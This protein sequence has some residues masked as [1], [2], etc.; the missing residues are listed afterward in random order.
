MRNS[1]L[2][3]AVI[4]FTNISLVFGHGD[5]KHDSTIMPIDNIKQKSYG[6]EK[7][8]NYQE[9][10]FRKITI[11]YQK[12]I[13]PIFENSCFN[14]HSQQVNYP[15]YYELPLVKNLIDEDIKEART[16]VIFGEGFP[17]QGHGEPSNDLKAI[18]ESVSE[19]EMPPLEYVVMHP[20]SYINEEEQVI[21]KKWVNES[22]EVLK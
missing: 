14:C 20:S 6:D 1:L 9:E 10:A 12:D 19:R 22:L 17:F 7:Q 13:K 15:W 16:H 2:F 11:A 4:F 21:I 3:L 8:V 18:R 5:E